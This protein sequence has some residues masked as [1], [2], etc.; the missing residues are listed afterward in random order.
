MINKVLLLNILSVF[1]IFSE[2]RAQ[3]VTILFSVNMSY[4]IETGNF[5]PATEFV[6]L[7][8]DFNGWGSDLTILSDDDQDSIYDISHSGFFISQN[9]QFKFRQNGAWDGSEEFP[10]GGPNRTFTVEATI[11]SLSFWYNDETSSTG[12][13]EANFYATQMEIKDKGSVQFLDISSGEIEYWNWFFEGG[14]PATSTLQ[15]PNVFYTNAGIFNVR[16]IVGNASN[17][18]TL[19]ITDFITVNERDRTQLSWWN[20][21][22]FYEAFVRSFYDSDGDGIGDFNGFIEKLDYLND[23]DIN[24]DEDL[25]IGGIWLMPINPSPSYHGY[26]VS[27]YYGINPDYG[28]MAEFQAFLDTA[29][30]RGIKVIIDLVM[31]HSSSQHQWFIDSKNYQNNKRNYYRW[32]QSNPGYNGPWGQQVWHWHNSGYYYG[33]FWGGMPDLNYDEPQ[34]VD[35]MFH[36][37]EYWLNDIGVD[38]FRLDA[39]GLIFEDGE[40]LEHVPATIQF[41]KDFS[42]HTKSIA[43]E[44]FA[45]GEVWTNTNTIANYVEDDGLDFCFEF[46]LA[47][48]ILNAVNN[49]DASSIYSKMSEV[50]NV[51]PYLQWGSFLTNHDM[52]RVMNSLAQDENK[53]KLAAAIYLTLPGIPFI[54]YGEE[55]GML[56]EKP[57]ED[58]RRPMQWTNGYQAGFTTGIPWNS[59]NGNYTSF[60]VQTELADSNSILNQYKKLIKVRNLKPA[61]QEGDYLEALADKN[62]VFSFL[63]ATEDDTALIVINTATNLISDIKLNLA[64]SGLPSGAYNWF[65]LMNNEFQTFQI[66]SEHLMT[67]PEMESMEVMILSSSQIIETHTIEVDLMVYLEGPFNGI[68]METSLNPSLLPLSHPYNTTP[69]NFNGSESVQSIPSP[70]IVD[71]VLI[72]LRDAIDVE[73]ANPASTIDKQAA[74]LLR[75]GS[76]VGMDGF[77]NLQFSGTIT[78]QL[79]VVVRHRNHID[80]ISA[81]PL[82]DI[83]G[84]FTYDF[85]TEI[86]HVYGG[87]AGYKSIGSGVYGMVGGDVDGSGMVY[88]T[89]KEIWALYGGDSGYLQEDQNMDG[90]V[91]N[92]DKNDI[93]FSN[94]NTKSSQVPE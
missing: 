89:D 43:P 29:H 47:G 77:S 9:I 50:Y 16:L 86:G 1:L 34:V 2:L 61:L 52:N 94:T 63:R 84:V 8:G 51:Y 74:F 90:E 24:T 26:D 22:V 69:W 67:I 54:Y 57:D 33:V 82:T 49:G 18:D 23:G 4:Q 46:D 91:N 56:G 92:L 68:D 48:T 73:N 83:N 35:S 87:I 30:A 28:T 3:D 59:I 44:S 81:N 14:N 7:A 66:N 6:D 21:T 38:G 88:I 60:N 55:I 78:E 70:D 5:D 27:N 72:E 40:N 79:F 62:A 76:V 75:N 65:D 31:N 45:V 20:N 93:W 64:N 12:S 58:I 15:N 13:P 10:G 37:A 85:S 42:A 41:W 32:S 53:N 25:G 71:W 11:N 17:S 36:V 39:A 19:L 80:I